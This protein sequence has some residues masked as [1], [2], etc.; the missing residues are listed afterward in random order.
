[1]SL[2]DVQDYEDIRAPELWI[3]RER[4]L[5]IYRFDGQHYQEREN[6]VIFPE[7][8]LKQLIPIYVEQA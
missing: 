5:H 7:L 3:Y 4:S 2:N 8:A 6:S 1:M